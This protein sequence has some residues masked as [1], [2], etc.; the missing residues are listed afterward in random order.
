MFEYAS[1]IVPTY[2]R[3]EAL[4]RVLLELDRQTTDDFEVVVGDDG[5]SEDTRE[6]IESL[7]GQV[8]YTLKH[9][10]QPDEGFRAARARNNAVLQA[11]GDYLIF[12]DGDCLPIE[13]FIECHRWLSEEG[14]WVRGTRVD[15][16][17][18]FTARVLAEDLPVTSWP[19]RRWAIAWMRGD[20]A[21]IA[22]HLRLRTRAFR[23]TRPRKWGGART[24]N[25]GVWRD[26][27]MRVDGFDESYR[28]SWGYEDSDL[29]IRLINSGV[30]R[31][32]GRYVMPVLHLWHP[33]V[34]LSM[35]NLEL[36][37]EL[38]EQG[39]TRARLGISQHMPSGPTGEESSGSQA[40]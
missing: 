4:R 15:L 16:S 25:M 17:E 10:W 33:R 1:V 40:G 11:E 19:F 2:N 24:C 22:P 35:E 6:T 18:E 21:R 37:N 32:E 3:P 30:R 8:G 23:K 20:A 12:L 26:D 34:P 14:W 39:A 29:V 38:I 27:F 9:A 36:L 31:I 28:G 13:G 7:K 5:S